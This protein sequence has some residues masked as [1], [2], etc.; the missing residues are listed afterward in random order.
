MTYLAKNV[1]F[2][3]NLAQACDR[4][5]ARAKA[6]NEAE[7]RRFAVERARKIIR[8][9]KGYTDSQLRTACGFYMTHGDGGPDYLT[10][11][12]HIYAINARERVAR[13]QARVAAGFSWDTDPTA[14]Q[15]AM[16]NRRKWPLIVL[17]GCIWA[18]GMLVATGWM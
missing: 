9:P 16:Q 11:D 5:T 13:N 17:C 2:L 10:A 14:L 3:P 12:A 6:E 18:L 1:T 4:I 7:E 8:N 15:I